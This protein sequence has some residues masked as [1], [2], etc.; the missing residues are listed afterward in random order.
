M[1]TDKTV[2]TER[3]SPVLWHFCWLDSML[4]ILRTNSFQLSES[5][6]DREALPGVAGWTKRCRWYMCT[7]RSKT[8][9]EGYSKIVSDDNR[10]GYARIQLDGDALNSVARGKASDYFGKRGEEDVMGKR[11]LYKNI[12]SGKYNGKTVA[13]VYGEKYGPV[14]DNEKEDTLWYNKNV[15]PNA[16]KY[17]QRVDVLIPTQETLRDN[18]QLFKMIHSAA[19]YLHIPVFFY[20]K[21]KEMDLQTDKTVDIQLI[22]N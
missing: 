17:I 10:E 9:D 3:L 13:D 20:T 12:E 8:S 1:N 16:N 4:N 15:L 14:Q 19:V 2:L 6:V 5:E 11:L 21:K 18:L 22:G 7:T